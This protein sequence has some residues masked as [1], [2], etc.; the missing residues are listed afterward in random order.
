VAASTILLAAVSSAVATLRIVETT[1]AA[2]VSEQPVVALEV[3]GRSP[4]RLDSPG[5]S[6]SS[7]ATDAT[8]MAKRFEPAREQRAAAPSRVVRVGAAAADEVLPARDLVMRSQ[9]TGSPEHSAAT[10]LTATPL[11]ATPI[12]IETVSIT[13]SDAPSESAGAPTP[14]ADTGS[15]PPWMAAAN[16]GRAVGQGSR[17]AGVAT[18]GFFTRL[19]KRIAGSF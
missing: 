8:P 6:D 17:N 5:V 12:S 11:A 3:E 18:A 16:A 19:G 10:T 4:S 14:P 9:A 7:A 2:S 15:A 13:H 1:A